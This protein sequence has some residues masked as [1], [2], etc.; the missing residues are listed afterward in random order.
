MAE[1]QLGVARDDQPK[2]FEEA[3]G[4]AAHYIWE[5]YE[6]KPSSIIAL[7]VVARFF[8]AIADEAFGRDEQHATWL[9]N[10]FGTLGA[11][12][13]WGETIPT[14]L[15]RAKLGDVVELVCRKQHDYGHQNILRFGLDGIIVRLSD[16]LARLEN[17]LARDLSPANESIKDTWD[18]VI[19]YSLIAIMLVRGTFLLPL[20][21]DLGEEIRAGLTT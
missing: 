20:A 21:A 5:L 19:G 12:A 17:L 1:F 6:P 11:R 14:N 13:V 10:R 16:K 15:V 2:T 8:N 7:A 4:Q 9:A 18:D 3:A